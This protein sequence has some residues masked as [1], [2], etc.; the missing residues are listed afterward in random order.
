MAHGTGMFE[1]RELREKLRRLEEEVAS[2]KRAADEMA[3]K[4]LERSGQRGV[5]QGTTSSQPV[6]PD[7]KPKA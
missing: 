7:T 6:A 5:T 3:R 4:A 2:T 1:Q